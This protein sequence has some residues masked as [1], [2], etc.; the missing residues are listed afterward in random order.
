MHA[1]ERAAYQ[2]AL[3]RLSEHR[4][5]AVV[6]V[7]DGRQVLVPAPRPDEIPAAWHALD[8]CVLDP[9]TGRIAPDWRIATDGRLILITPCRPAQSPKP[10]RARGARVQVSLLWWTRPWSA[11]RG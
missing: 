11:R 3:E 10:S 2:R 4:S 6:I 5:K 1:A 9:V 7:G 8:G